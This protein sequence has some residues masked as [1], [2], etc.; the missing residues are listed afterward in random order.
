M[1]QV[2][3]PWQFAVERGPDWLFVRL[4]PPANPLESAAGVADQ[5]WQMM[6]QH[7]V[8][9]LVLEMDQVPLLSSD[10]IGQLVMLHKRIVMH[11]GLLRLAGLSRGNEDVLRMSRLD[12]RF[13]SYADRGAAVTG[14]RPGQPR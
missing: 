12:G 11:G 5:L 7:F 3:T 9:R 8:N 2:A 6:Q 10:L 14:T 1:V 4:T 13:P